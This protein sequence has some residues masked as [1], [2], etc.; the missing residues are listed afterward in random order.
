M[1]I[2]FTGDGVLDEVRDVLPASE[3]RYV[4]CNLRVSAHNDIEIKSEK[5][6]KTLMLI[7]IPDEA[8][9]KDRA[10]YTSAADAFRERLRRIN[11]ML[12]IYSFDDVDSDII[13]ERLKISQPSSPA[14]SPH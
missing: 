2:D 9:A 10:V 7:W 14:L 11:R 4:V 5:V 8:S 3:P 12:I 13:A 6:T 1:K